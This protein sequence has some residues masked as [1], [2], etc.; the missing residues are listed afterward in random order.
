HEV[1]G[2]GYGDEAPSLGTEI[3]SCPHVRKD[4]QRQVEDLG[5]CGEDERERDAAR[6]ALREVVPGCMRN[7]GS[8]EQRDSSGRHFLTGGDGLPHVALDVVRGVL[9]GTAADLADEDDGGSFG[10]VVEEL[11]GFSLGGTDDGVA[12]DADAGRLA[13]ASSRELI[14]GFINERAAAGYDA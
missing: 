3:L 12:A 13:D 2:A 8:E 7:S 1:E 9:L 14:D 10:V 4:C 5:E 11:E 6:G